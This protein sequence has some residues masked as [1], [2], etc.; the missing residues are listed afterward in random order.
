MDSTLDIDHSEVVTLKDRVRERLLP[1][2][3]PLVSTIWEAR[4]G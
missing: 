2:L 4:E 1:F 3:K